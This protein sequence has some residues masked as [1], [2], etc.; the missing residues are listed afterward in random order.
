M[1]KRNRRTLGAK[2]L[3]SNPNCDRVAMVVLLENSQG[4]YRLN[5]YICADCHYPM[6]M[7]IPHAENCEQGRSPG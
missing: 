1:P 7:E 4:C 6:M 5:K 3:C 2:L